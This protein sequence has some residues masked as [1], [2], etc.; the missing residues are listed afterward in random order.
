MLLN[1]GLVLLAVGGLI[2]AIFL[3]VG[4]R[5]NWQ[6]TRRAALLEHLCVV[7]SPLSFL[8]GLLCILSVP[9]A[10]TS[11]E[12]VRSS[13]SGSARSSEVLSA[14]LDPVAIKI[15]IV[16]VLLSAAP[17]GAWRWRHR[18]VVE[19]LAALL[20][21]VFILLSFATVGLALFPS[22]LFMFAASA[23]GV[24]VRAHGGTEP[25]TAH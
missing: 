18:Y 11:I 21:G 12:Q 9:V 7:L 3:L 23:F 20:L 5:R 2:L 8:A 13:A 24:W 1:V 16:V 6:T 17:L 19:L 15:L 22:A 14:S 4:E 10:S 25:L